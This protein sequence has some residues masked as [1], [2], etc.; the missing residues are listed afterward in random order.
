M[1]TRLTPHFVELIYDAALKSFWRKPALK[2]FLQGSQVPSA[3]LASWDDSETKRI[4]LNRLFDSLRAHAKAEII[5]TDLAKALSEQTAFPD[6]LGWED[7]DHKLAEARQAVARLR[8]Y[9]EEQDRQLQDKETEAES[10][11][12]FEER[13]AEISKSQQSLTSLQESLNVFAAELGTQA[14]GYKFQ[15]WFYDL[16]DFFEVV[17]RR[18]YVTEGR[19]IDGAVTL[20]DTTYLVELKFTL[21]PSGPD[22]IDSLI[23]KV[24]TK[25]DNTLG[26]LVSMSGLTEIAKSEASRN[27]T[28]LVLLDHNHIYHVLGG[29]MSFPELID[30]AKRHAA[31]TG[32]SYLHP[33]DFNG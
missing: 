7:T 6:L 25:A 5:F 10:K 22:D 31:Q 26:I 12:R 23:R 8:Q 15:D 17:S 29:R 24:T 27:R 1:L 13:Q 3:F 32:N 4:F 21:S 19:Q 16:M 33:S 20:K 2:R 28:L 30:R 18:P 11:K 9:I 14:G